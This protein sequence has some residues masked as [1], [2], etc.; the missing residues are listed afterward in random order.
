MYVKAAMQRG[1]RLR[2]AML[3]SGGRSSS[4]AGQRGG[5]GYVAAMLRGEKAAW[6]RAAG[7]SGPGGRG[8]S[9]PLPLP[10]LALSCALSPYIIPCLLSSLLF[11][12]VCLFIT[13]PFIC[14]LPSS[15]PASRHLARRPPRP[16]LH[17]PTCAALRCSHMQPHTKTHSHTDCYQE[18]A[19]DEPDCVYLY[20]C[21]HPDKPI[22]LRAKHKTMEKH[23]NLVWM[24]LF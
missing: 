19:E 24:C 15:N 2:A 13:V 3:W 4:V 11:R 8:E 7:C 5:A 22:G 18:Q 23:E 16:C 12:H 20:I 1:G 17:R 14:L 10:P 9:D 21:C 6:L